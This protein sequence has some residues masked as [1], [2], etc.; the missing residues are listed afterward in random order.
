MLDKTV[1]L[2]Y[3]YKSG[4]VR[5]WHFAQNADKTALDFVQ[6]IEN[7]GKKEQQRGC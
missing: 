2:C 5:N 3:H 6:A 4:I 7:S 1:Y